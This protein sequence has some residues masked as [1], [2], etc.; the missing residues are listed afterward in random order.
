VNHVLE[1]TIKNRDDFQTIPVEAHQI[2]EMK[3][4]LDE[5]IEGH[6][7]KFLSQCHVLKEQDS[8]KMLN[9]C[10]KELSSRGS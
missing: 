1:C 8:D 3:G 7:N 2:Y 6:T 10:A 9:T 4:I 5:H